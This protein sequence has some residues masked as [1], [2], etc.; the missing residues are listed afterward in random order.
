MDA[1]DILALFDRPVAFH[2]VFVDYTGSTNAAIMLSQA[3]Y[4]SK[5]TRPEADGWFYKSQDE[6]T[7]ELR[8]TR[9][10]Q[11]GARKLLR[12]AGFWLEER[13]GNPAK[14]YYKIDLDAFQ[15]VVFGESSVHTRMA[16]TA[17]DEPLGET[18]KPPISEGENR[19]TPR[20][21]LSDLTETT[22]ET[23]LPIRPKKSGKYPHKKLWP[24]YIS[25]FFAVTNFAPMQQLWPTIETS[26]GPT[27]DL[28]RLKACYVAWVSRGYNPKAII[29][30]DW[31][32]N[33]SIPE[34]FNNGGNGAGKN[35]QPHFIGT[36]SKAEMD[37]I[38]RVG[39]E[40]QANIK[41]M[42]AAKK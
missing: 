14:M 35:D 13:K 10:E 2:P 6:W 7:A 23:T 15:T 18:P 36:K 22:T 19:H 38:N 25:L 26:M 4:W 30:L 41:R 9:R 3:F 5:R 28:R 12:S 16:K 20:A 42:E 27:P 29:W 17:I 40:F 11:E 8:L 34:R 32:A 24:R 39:A 37:E 21:P 31:Y 1:K 33:N